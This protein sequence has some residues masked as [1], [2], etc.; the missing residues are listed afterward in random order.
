[1]LAILKATFSK[2]ENAETVP[3]CDIGYKPISM[4]LCLILVF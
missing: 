2:F 3:N 1:V 4:I